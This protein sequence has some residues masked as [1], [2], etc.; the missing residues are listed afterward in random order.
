MAKKHNDERPLDPV[1]AAKSGAGTELPEELAPPTI[2]EPTIPEVPSP[3]PPAESKPRSAHAGKTF[4]VAGTSVVT[5]SWK[6]QAVRFHPGDEVSEDGYG[7]GAVQSFI[8]S[9]V[10]LQEKK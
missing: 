3:K 8:D 6:G 9:G 5:A 7:D 1:E 2:E 4:V 10:A